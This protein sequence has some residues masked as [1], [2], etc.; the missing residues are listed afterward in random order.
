MYWGASVLTLA[1]DA[2]RNAGIVDNSIASLLFRASVPVLKVQDLINIVSDPEAKM[3]F[4]KRIELLNYQMSN[5][6]MAVVDAEEDLSNLEL[7]ALSGLDQILERYYVLVSSAT[8]IPVT[9]LIGESAH[10]LNA[11]GEGD[12]NNYYDMLETYQINKIKPR[13]LNIL[14]RWVVPS[15]FDELL[16]RDFD[17]VFPALE[18][19]SETQKQERNS[20]FVDLIIRCIDAEL[21]T[22]KVGRK[23]IV[24]RDVFNNFNEEDIEEMEKELG[25]NEVSL[26]DALDMADELYNKGD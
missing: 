17:I 24:E 7:G 13:L 11:T 15:Y 25:E 3:A 4:M 18:R 9:K 20:S 22:K 26:T 14:K 23:E 19:E 8:G 16:P 5:N 10:G 21:I 2:I 1:Y 6:N 12:L